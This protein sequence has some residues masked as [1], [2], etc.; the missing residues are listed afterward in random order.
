[1]AAETYSLRGGASAWPVRDHAHHTPPPRASSAPAAESQRP[2]AGAGGTYPGWAEAKQGEP[3]AAPGWATSVAAAPP[4]P[5][6]PVLQGTPVRQSSWLIRAARHP[7]APR[8]GAA[9]TPEHPGC[10]T[11]T[12]PGSC[13]SP[14][15]Q[16]SQC[17]WASDIGATGAPARGGDR[18]GG[19]LRVP[20]PFSPSV[21][22]E[23]PR[24]RDP[25]WFAGTGVP[26]GPSPGHGKMPG[27][28]RGSRACRAPV[29]VT[30]PGMR[31][32]TGSAKSSRLSPSPPPK[33]PP[34]SGTLLGSGCCWGVPAL[35]GT[36]SSAD[37]MGPPSLWSP[38]LRGP[39]PMGP[40]VW[41]YPA[42]GGPPAR[43]ALP[44][45]PPRDPPVPPAGWSP[46]R[47]PLAALPRS[48]Q[49]HVS[50][51]CR[52]AALPRAPRGPPGPGRGRK[53]RGGRGG[54]KFLRGTAR[55]GGRRRPQN[56]L[57]LRLLLLLLCSGPAPAVRSRRA[58]H[59]PG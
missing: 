43:E 28:S 10:L 30:R 22:T 32:G 51:R 56:F 50:P 57:L 52:G 40:P 44:L 33:D 54:G 49:S 48:P 46:F 59:A 18:R 25:H 37:L 5:S 7:A 41:G 53:R 24:G 31:R 47:P 21:R 8:L 20:L 45:Q 34:A 13:S 23:S 11:W 35:T 26:V 16:C 29:A 42:P 27:A 17:H 4:A 38:Q 58:R 36:P 55:G 9:L 39:G 1:M 2:L 12:P 19:G 14:C 15:G 3:R 6:S